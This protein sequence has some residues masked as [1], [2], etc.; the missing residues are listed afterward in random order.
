MD[1][2]LDDRL[3]EMN[4]RLTSVESR[5]DATAAA[6]SRRI[7]GIDDRLTSIDHRLGKVHSE[8]VKHNGNHH[9]RGT[10]VKQGGIVATILASAVG[11]WEVLRRFFITPPME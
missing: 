5:V 2:E 11:V 7:A 1:K 10:I 4:S 3:A 6:A 8:L 9:G